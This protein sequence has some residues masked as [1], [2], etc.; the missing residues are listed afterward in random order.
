MI[1]GMHLKGNYFHIY[2]VNRDHSGVMMWN[3]EISSFS[4]HDF[5]KKRK[6]EPEC[7]HLGCSIWWDHPINERWAESERLG[8]FCFYQNITRLG[9]RPCSNIN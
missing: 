8:V 1:T 5:S 7:K 2:L 9:L 3:R 6:P 4:R